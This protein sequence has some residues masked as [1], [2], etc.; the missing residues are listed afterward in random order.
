MNRAIKHQE[1]I[2]DDM[3]HSTEPGDVR[4]IASDMD[5]TL[6]DADGLVPDSF[7]PLLD[8]LLDAGIL[9]APASGRQ[10]QTLRSIFGDRPGLIYIAEN[11]TNVVRDDVSIAKE[12][13]E[14]SIISPIVEWVRATAV[15]GA[16]IGIVVCGA[17]SAYVERADTEFLAQVRRYYSALEIV[18]DVLQVASE[19][20]VLKLAIYDRGRAE[21]RTGPALLALDLTADVVVSGAD[22]VDVMRPGVNKGKALTHLQRALGITRCQTMAFGDFLNDVEMLDAAEHSYA[23]ANAHQI[24]LDHARYTAPSNVDGGVVTSII[25]AIPGLSAAVG[26]AT[27]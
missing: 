5:G 9:F 8:N 24:V 17:K 6:L 7:W 14:P 18:Q 19:D 10:Y 2:T 27:L 20:D 3:T 23:V 16:D 25:G 13:V 15:S 12:P 4:L 21:T 22:W 26:A 11:G 1:R